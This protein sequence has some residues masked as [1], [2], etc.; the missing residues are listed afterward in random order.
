LGVFTINGIYPGP[1]LLI[2]EPVLINEL[3][4]SLLF[5]NIA[6]LVMLILWLRPF[7]M[8]VKVPSGILSAVILVMSLVGIYSVNTSFFD[9]GVALV[10]GVLGY[11]LLRFDWPVVN[12]VMGVVLGSIFEQ[13]LREGLSNSAGNPLVFFERP[14]S[15]T[16]LIA[17]LLIIILPLWNDYRKKHQRN[18]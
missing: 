17:A 7:A 8:I 10:F 15:C 6:C 5:I 14:L 11:V 1:L 16:I 18:A 3:Y 2:K 12:L 4:V 13:R 9:V